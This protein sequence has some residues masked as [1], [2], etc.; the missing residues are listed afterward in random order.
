MLI[1]DGIIVCAAVLMVVFSSCNHAVIDY[2][3]NA[4]MLR[5]CL[6]IHQSHIHE[7]RER[8]FK[9]LIYT[10]DIAHCY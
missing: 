4:W 9:C 7:H 10:S 1:P 2:E 5:E 3:M 8:A 6:H